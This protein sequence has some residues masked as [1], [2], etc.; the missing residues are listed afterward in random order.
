MVNVARRPRATAGVPP[1]KFSHLDRGARYG[2][3]VAFQI[4]GVIHLPNRTET[5]FFVTPFVKPK[6]VRIKPSKPF[7]EPVY[8]M[9]PI[10]RMAKCKFVCWTVCKLL[11][12]IF[13]VYVVLTAILIIKHY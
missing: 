13:V 12:H 11:L 10:W 1:A 3:L 4:E 2:D 7:L 5:G 6:L 8:C 9:K